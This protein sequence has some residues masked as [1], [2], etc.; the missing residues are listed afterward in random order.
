MFGYVIADREI[1]TE[2]QVGR[3]R[4]YYCGL[5][6]TLK[7]EYGFM[8]QMTLTYDMT[9][10]VIFLSSLY[11]SVADMETHRFKSHPVKKQLML[12]NE[13]TSYAAAINVLL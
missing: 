2:E 7:E 11:E 6:R 8:G 4:A 9:F 13:I 3:Y 5:C 12:R 10:A 1:M